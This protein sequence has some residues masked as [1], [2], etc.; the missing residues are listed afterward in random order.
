MGNK[1]MIKYYFS[2]C[3]KPLEVLYREDFVKRYPMK[4]PRV[5]MPGDTEISGISYYHVN[6]ILPAPYSPEYVLLIAW[7]GLLQS[8]PDLSAQEKLKILASKYL[9]SKLMTL[10]MEMFASDKPVPDGQPTS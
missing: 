9:A 7:Y 3:Y 4:P 5:P 6:L 8:C 10:I 1:L 2:V